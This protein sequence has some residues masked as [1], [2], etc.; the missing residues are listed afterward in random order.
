MEARVGSQTYSYPVSVT[1]TDVLE[2]PG[3]PKVTI[4]APETDGHTT[5]EVRWTVEN[6]GP[7]TL[8]YLLLYC[9]SAQC[10]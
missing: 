7:D 8:Y 5:L 3:K 6:T 9:E 2:P 4:E 10:Q 1:V